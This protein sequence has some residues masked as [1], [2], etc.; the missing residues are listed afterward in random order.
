MKTRAVDRVAVGIASA[1]AWV[2]VL[3]AAGVARAQPPAQLLKDLRTGHGAAVAEGPQELCVVGGTVFFR[4]HHTLT[5][6]ELWA[7]DGTAAGTRLVKDI[8]IGN[9]CSI[10]ERL[11]AFA[12]KVFF[13]ADD[14][15]TGTELWMSDGTAAGTVLVKDI[16][17]GAGA[18][19]PRDLTVLTP[20]RLLFSASDGVNGRELWVTNGTTAGTMLVKDINA[21]AGASGITEGKGRFCAVANNVY[22]AANAGT[23]GLELWKSDGSPGG[24]V[25]VKEINTAAGAGGMNTII[26]GQ[27]SVN[28]VLA[29]TAD[30]GVNGEE[31]WVSNGTTAGTVLVKNIA[32]GAG[33]P[34]YPNSLRVVGTAPT[35]ILYFGAADGSN[36]YELWRT[37]GTTPGTF[38]TKEVA[39]GTLASNPLPIA[40]IGNVLYFCATDDGANNYELYSTQ[41]TGATTALVKDIV[42][43]SAG[44]APFP[45]IALGSTLIFTATG[46]TVG[47]VEPYVSDGTATG[48]V[49]L[50]DINVGANPSSPANYALLGSSVLF[51][52]DDGV[53]GPELWITDGTGP[54]TL[55]LKNTIGEMAS[56]SPAGFAALG[57][58]RVLFAA[59]D[60]SAGNELFVTDANTAGATNLLADLASGPTGSTPVS[61]T[62]WGVPGAPSPLALVFAKPAGTQRAMVVNTDT[63]AATTL[64]TTGTIAATPT[65]AV[66]NGRAFVPT[67]TGIW[68]SDGTV[69]GTAQA[70]PG[71]ATLALTGAQSL[72]ALGDRL[73]FFG[74]NGDVGYEP[75]VLSAPAAPGVVG[76]YT[77]LKNIA[78]GP[79]ASTVAG[80]NQPMV[81]QGGFVYFLAIDGLFTNL[82][83]TD[84]TAAGTVAVKQV[85]IDFP[86]AAPLVGTGTRLFFVAGN[87]ATPSGVE[88]WTST[89]SVGS[90]QLVVDL[91]PGAGS[92]NVQNLT[93]CDGSAYF[94]AL[95]PGSGRNDLYVC[96]D[97]ATVVN[98]TGALSGGLPPGALVSS[99]RCAGRIVWFRLD[100]GVNGPELWRTNG[101]AAGTFMVSDGEAGPLGGLPGGMTEAGPTRVVY[102]AQTEASG[103]EVFVVGVC[104]TDFNRDGIKDPDDLGDYITGYFSE[105]PDPRSEFNFDTVINP[106]DLGDFITAYF[107]VCG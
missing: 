48:T 44:S 80:T 26:D 70:L 42:P 3:A 92:S 93:A 107:E 20:T 23:T 24:T 1:C 79:L 91:T 7:S 88:L 104:S 19:T 39:A 31:L 82:W 78:G 106:D 40:S 50:K 66:I 35:Q 43:G 5:G 62:P 98:L 22:F 54:A 33:N 56:S 27:V 74:A 69:G 77:L 58:G 68:H 67:S 53:S 87:A 71:P 45:G 28:G 38:L 105:P 2:C 89:G 86:A 84:G 85:P 100:D 99:V 52:A 13:T 14:S 47:N 76:T 9:V 72:A 51:T 60:G 49:R 16:N 81:V 8:R 101:T 36:N 41:G 17:P 21:T 75:F 25:L 83:R 59:T 61:I 37:D 11:T 65:A 63:S 95:T 30:D 18:S 90:G 97:G 103:R 94:T 57:D 73:V 55:L 96:T 15:F 6:R 64:P 10:P 46:I 4:V 102:A 34:S 12:G 32:P 29:F